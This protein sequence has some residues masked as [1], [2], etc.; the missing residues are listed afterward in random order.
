[1]RSSIRVIVI[2]AAAAVILMSSAFSEDL[3]P[4][5]LGLKFSDFTEDSVRTLL[6]EAGG[7]RVVKLWLTHDARP[8]RTD[9]S[10]VNI[11]CL[12]E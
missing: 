2:I 9:E 11:L 1:M 5:P 12:A 10:W 4:W 3:L 8:G 7:F 6:E